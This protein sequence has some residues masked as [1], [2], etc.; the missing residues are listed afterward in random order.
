MP[1]PLPRDHR[2]PTGGGGRFPAAGAEGVRVRPEMLP[3]PLCGVPFASPTTSTL[4]FRGKQCWSKRT[5]NGCLVWF[6]VQ[7]VVILRPLEFWTAPSLLPPGVTV[8]AVARIQMLCPVF[9]P[10]HCIPPS[11]LEVLALVWCCAMEQASWARHSAWAGAHTEG[12]A[13]TMQGSG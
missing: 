1:S 7:A 3:C 8:M 9:I 2:H 5:W 4:A 13:G 6:S 11:A 10:Y 12:A